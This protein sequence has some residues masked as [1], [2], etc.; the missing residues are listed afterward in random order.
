MIVV[1]KV[2]R[3]G[4]IHILQRIHLSAELR[5]RFIENTKCQHINLPSL[6]IG[7][8]LLLVL[9]FFFCEF[10]IVFSRVQT[11]ADLAVEINGGLPAISIS[12]RGLRFMFPIISNS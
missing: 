9:V 4:A 2:G 8:T 5:H 10:Y 7:R 6:H 1:S 12:I 11:G 3:K